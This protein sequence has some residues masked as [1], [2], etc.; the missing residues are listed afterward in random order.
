MTY[1]LPKT[2]HEKLKDAISRASTKKRKRKD[3]TSANDVYS[4]MAI[5]SMVAGVDK[6]APRQPAGMSKGAAAAAA[7]ATAKVP[8]PAVDNF[9]IFEDVGKYVPVGALVE[10]ESQSQ[11][12]SVSPGSAVPPPLAAGGR[13][14]GA[15]AGTMA[16]KVD[17]LSATAEEK[18][19]DTQQT[20]K[21]LFSNLLAAPMDK[22]T[23]KGKGLDKDKPEDLMAPVRAALRA[24]AEREKAKIAR[25]E[26]KAS[27][28]SSVAA[29][30]APTSLAAAAKVG[31]VI[32]RDVFGTGDVAVKKGDAMW[33]G[34]YDIYP[35][36]GDYEVTTQSDAM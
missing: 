24:E 2:I 18:P 31:N 28:S 13:T 1:I 27:G 29:V 32:H 36:N 26:A 7:A 19:S 9:D 25:T 34:T 15:D 30:D 11:S 5:K 17:T 12:V 6:S 21:G 4:M 23:D 22:E 8:T 20:L 16:K 14:E 3:E 35:E 33:H 10:D